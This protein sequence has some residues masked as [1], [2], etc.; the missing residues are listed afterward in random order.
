M[1]AGGGCLGRALGLSGLD[2]AGM[3][4]SFH[5]IARDGDVNN[6]LRLALSKELSTKAARLR[7][8]AFLERAPAFIAGKVKRQAPDVSHSAIYAWEQSR[9]LSATVISLSITT[10]TAESES[11]GH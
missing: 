10:P 8:E 7:Y 5:A 4:A 3:E 11:Y 9:A 1:A 2:I 6:E